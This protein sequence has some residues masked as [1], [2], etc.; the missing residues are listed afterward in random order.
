[1]DPKDLPRTLRR[2]LIENSKYYAEKAKRL[3]TLADILP[4]MDI[5]ETKLVRAALK[6]LIVLDEERMLIVEAEFAAEHP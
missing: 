6:D 3:R 1:M 5:E 2:C 4:H